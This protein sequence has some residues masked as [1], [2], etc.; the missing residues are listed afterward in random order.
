MILSVTILFSLSETLDH[1]RSQRASRERLFGTPT[2]PLPIAGIR[3][4]ALPMDGG[5]A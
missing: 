1:L 4:P 3:I 2:G 5:A